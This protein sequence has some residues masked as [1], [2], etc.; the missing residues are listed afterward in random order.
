M[1]MIEKALTEG[2]PRP[3]Q[4]Y[5]PLVLEQIRADFL[6]IQ[7]VDRQLMRATSTPDTLDLAFVVKSAAEIRK[8]SGRLKRNLALPGPTSVNRSMGAVEAKIEPLRSSLSVLSKLIEE[9]VSNPMFEQLKLVDAQLSAKARRDLEA[10]IDLSGEIK[11]SSEKL[12]AAAKM[13]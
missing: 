7:V 5:A 12:K 11:R 10:V 6:R 13:R 9:F 4:P 1:R 2:R 8:R 3:A